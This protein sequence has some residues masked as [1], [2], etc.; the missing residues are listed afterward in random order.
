[1][2]PESFLTAFLMSV[3]T[4]FVSTVATV[5]VLKNDITWVKKSLNEIDQRVTHHEDRYHPVKISHT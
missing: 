4:G 5:S 2:P 1:M 3:V